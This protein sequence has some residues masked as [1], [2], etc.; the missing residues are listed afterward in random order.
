MLYH[1]ALSRN[2]EICD[3]NIAEPI[4]ERFRSNLGRAN[5][6]GQTALTIYAR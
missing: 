3:T 6:M 2:H 1:F 5:K 4:A